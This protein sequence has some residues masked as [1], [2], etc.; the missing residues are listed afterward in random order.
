MSSREYWRRREAAQLEKNITEEAAYNAALQKIYSTMIDSIDSDIRSF[1]SRYATSEGITL[2]EAKR[3]AD[4][5]DIEE[6]ARKAARYVETKDFS[7]QANEEMKLYNMTMKVNRLEL[8]KANI[9][10]EMTA[11]YNDIEKMMGDALTKRTLE[12]IERQAGIL[13][14]TINNNADLANSIVNASFHNATWSDRVWASQEELHAKVAQNLTKG[15]IQGVN[16]RTLASNLIPLIQDDV[17]NKR[18]A[19]ERLMR[20]ELARVQIDAQKRS[21]IEGDYEEYEIICDF[22]ACHICK[23]YDGKHYPVDKMEIGENAP[24]FHPNCRCSTAVYVGGEI[25]QTGGKHYTPY[26]ENDERDIKA[27]REYRKISRRNDAKRIAENTG[28]SEEDVLQIKRHIF[29]DKHQT[30]EGYK[31][32]DPDYDMAVAWDRLYKG[33][34][35]DRDILLLKHELL[36]SNL[37][38]Q[39]N[40]TVAEAHQRAKKSYDWE[41]KLKTDL[42]GGKEKDGLL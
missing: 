14:I 6:Y 16:S 29:Y 33:E 8:L 42:Q 28:F 32:L 38:K 26:N 40:L 11:G 15:L 35:L 20:T 1:Y 21:Y 2:A 27:A 9:G 13:G 36:E 5:L 17:K 7:E 18:A 24:P 30:Y 34:Q 19:A 23:P 37:E 10:A 39:Y 25:R 3:R 22:Q 4:K 12:E 41:K 31:T